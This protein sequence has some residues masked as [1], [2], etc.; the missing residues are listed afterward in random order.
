MNTTPEFKI[1]D[2]FSLV[3]GGPL[4][5]LFV[6]SR[7]AT[8]GLDWLKRRIIFFV[9]L[10]WLPLLLLSA[11][12]GQL[13]E[14]S[15]KVPFLYDLETH[16]RFL[17]ALPLLLLAEL[18][19]HQRMRPVVQQFIDREIITAETRAGFD[20]SIVSALRLRNSI[21]ME[22]A[23]I[24]GVLSYHFIWSKLATLDTTIW[25]A[26]GLASEQQLSLAGYWLA[27][28]SLPVFQFMMFRWLFRI[29]VWA[30]FLWQ[31][32]RLDLYLVPTH[33]DKAGGLG[34]LAGSAA[35]F[36]PLILA[37]GA[38]L[39]A[40]IAERIFY[41]GA[42]LLDFKPEIV[43]S[44]VFLLLLI[45]GPLCVF[46]GRLAQTKR[47]GSLRYGSLA[48]RYVTE[49]ERK[50]L[51]GG[52]ASDEAFIGSGDIQSLADLNNSLETIRTMRI[53]P[54]S[55]ETVLQIVAATLLPVLPLALTMISLE[56]I[57]KRLLGILL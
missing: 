5:Q 26:N 37:L 12:S 50:W 42:K 11:A 23:L 2:D 15:V 25:Y 33:P 35:A 30:R 54:F 16:V 49:F 9:L 46:S 28:I 31:V 34:F 56:D 10:T 40:M 18:V 55:K 20:A 52:A 41:E 57:V 29:I 51:Q 44:A 1:P 13:L 32:S 24:F 14:G 17:V 7:L 39:S 36:I 27:S 19:V 22:I 8:S 43:A 21:W 4:F 38:L 48:S 45:L 53:F 6:R 47:E 3:Q